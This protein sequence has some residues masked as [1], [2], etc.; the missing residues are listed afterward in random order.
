MRTY[1][2]SCSDAA[3]TLC[4]L[5]FYLVVD[6]SPKKITSLTDDPK[7]G[8]IFYKSVVRDTSGSFARRFSPPSF[9]VSDDAAENSPSLLSECEASSQTNGQTQATPNGANIVESFF[10]VKFMDCQISVQDHLHKVR[11]VCRM[12]LGDKACG[13]TH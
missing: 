6:S 13:F 5:V 3:L 4:S 10:M 8:A 11:Y 7:F 12:V 9:L 2:H 1:Y